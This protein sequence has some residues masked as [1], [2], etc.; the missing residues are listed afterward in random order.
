RSS[1]DPLKRRGAI[2]PRSHEEAPAT[3]RDRGERQ[4]PLRVFVVNTR[5]AQREPNGRDGS[6]CRYLN[7]ARISTSV[8][9]AVAPNGM[10]GLIPQPSGRLPVRSARSKSSK[11]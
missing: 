7:T 10:N 5:R 11:L 6:D 8:I 9:S 1:S 4:G 2:S 3:H